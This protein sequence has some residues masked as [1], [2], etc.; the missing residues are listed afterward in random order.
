MHWC[1]RD[2]I[3]S[4]L[5][6]CSLLAVVPAHAQS[7]FNVAVGSRADELR[8]DIASS[9]GTPNIISELR[10]DA[11]KMAYFSAQLTTG[12]DAMVLKAAFGRGEINSGKNQDSDYGA[13]NRGCEFSRSNNDA[14]IG[15]AQDFE[16]MVGFEFPG[17]VWGNTQIVPFMGYG[18]HDLNLTMRQGMQT[19][20]NAACL[21]AGLEGFPPP[22]GPIPG[23]NSSYDAEWSGLILGGE[24][25]FDATEQLRITAKY[26][27]RVINYE[28]NANWNL[29]A[30]LEHPVSFS[31]SANGYGN[32]FSLAARY[33]V[34][35]RIAFGVLYEFEN[36]R[37]DP[38]SDFVFGSDG[39]LGFTVLN[40]VYW[41]S[42]RWLATITADF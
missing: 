28:A 2:C 23:L 35:E 4:V 25:Y 27:R 41:Q 36:Y 29:R 24:A 39:G 13:D 38:G 33:Q 17:L 34:D 37:T 16:F 42:S 30:D 9:T 8:W 18:Q 10:W 32:V 12:F 40:E 7:D 31:Q 6:A 21:P 3:A 11:L 5:V 19:I 20:S 22:L 1:H 26:L 15:N 14:S